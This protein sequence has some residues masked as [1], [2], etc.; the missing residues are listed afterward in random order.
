[1]I[2]VTAA[3]TPFRMRLSK[4]EPVTLS[5]DVENQSDEQ[6]IATIAISLGG[7][8]SFEKGGYKTDEVIRLPDLKPGEK[9]RYYYD[10]HPKAGTKAQEQRIAIKVLEHYQNFN[11]VTKEYTKTLSLQVQD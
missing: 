7:Q 8:L 3:F 4:R 1:M 11:Y 9:K 10:V 6:K 5:V 2:Q